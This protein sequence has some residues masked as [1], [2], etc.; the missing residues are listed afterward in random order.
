MLDGASP[1]THK[2][3]G[4]FRLLVGRENSFAALTP[5]MRDLDEA[6]N[7]LTWDLAVP[8]SR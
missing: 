4:F 5:A 2:P 1:P 6:K 3:A 8:T 7:A